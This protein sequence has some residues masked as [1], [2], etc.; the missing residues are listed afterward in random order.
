M[1]DLREELL[2]LAAEYDRVVIDLGAGFERPIR[3]MALQ[4]GM[5]LVVTTEEPTALTD[6]YAFIK[7]IHAVKPSAD[8]RIV[9]NMAHSVREGE[10]TY[11]VLSR[12]CQSFLHLSPPL[13]RS[14]EH[15]SELQSLMRNSYAGFCL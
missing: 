3:Q 13:A 14:E 2:G 8:M 1:A 15:T 10:R 11:D 5:V 7:V 9:V 4:S 12:A 6:A